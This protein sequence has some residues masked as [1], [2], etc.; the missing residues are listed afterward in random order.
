VSAITAKNNLLRSKWS[1]KSFLDDKSEQHYRN[2]VKNL[3]AEPSVKDVFDFKE[4]QQD[5][6]LS[7][8]TF[9]TS[10]SID[11]LKIID[12]KYL[13]IQCEWDKIQNYFL[14]NAA[15]D[16]TEEKEKAA[17]NAKILRT[18]LKLRMITFKSTLNK[19]L[20]DQNG[21]F[22]SVECNINTVKYSQLL[23]GEKIK[24]NGNY[25]KFNTGCYIIKINGEDIK[26]YF[27][28]NAAGSSN[29][30]SDI[31]STVNFILGHSEKK[32]VYQNFYAVSQLIIEFHKVFLKNYNFNSAKMYDLNLYSGNFSKKEIMEDL[33]NLKK[34]KE[35]YI[36]FLATSRLSV[37]MPLLKDVFHKAND[38]QKTT[39]N[40]LI[41][42]KLKPINELLSQ[43]QTC[44]NYVFY[45][46]K[47]QKEDYTNLKFNDIKSRKE[48]TDSRNKTHYRCLTNLMNTNEILDRVC[49]IL[50][51]NYYAL[52]A[53][54]PPGA[55]IDIMN[56]QGVIKDESLM[57]VNFKIDNLL[58]NFM[59]ALEH[60]FLFVNAE[61]NKEESGIIAEIKDFS[62]YLSRFKRAANSLAESNDL[63]KCTEKAYELMIKP[64]EESTE[65][66][67]CDKKLLSPK[68]YL[69]SDCNG[70]KKSLKCELERNKDRSELMKRFIETVFKCVMDHGLKIETA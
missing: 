3:S 53:Y 26:G 61:S 54:I 35:K 22:K 4:D 5:K 7:E 12:Q 67:K 65:E 48:S 46:D 38:T 33:A 13:P 2:Y 25:A 45:P 24:L 58:Q 18:F 47:D 59:F 41:D 30:S 8:Q 19:I 1:N 44:G 37:I 6:K 56:L 62:K 23:T 68:N 9:D 28:F 49:N 63:G 40:K 66:D 11:E 21:I 27:E 70:I 64:M 15:N 60:Y 17:E 39:F 29:L 43:S 52:E 20:Q 16:S 57:K 31:D 36:Q 34:N 32:K 14:K 69:L 10:K 51:G 55:I 50:C 42:S